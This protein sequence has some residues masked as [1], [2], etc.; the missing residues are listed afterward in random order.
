M[1]DLSKQEKK[2]VRELIE[3]G[4]IRDY[5]DGI[6]SAKDVCDSYIEGKSD[7]KEYYHKLFSVLHSKDKIIAKRYDGITGSHYIMRLG[8][9]FS[10]GVLTQ[11][12][13]Q[14]VDE[15]LKKKLSPYM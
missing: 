9:L 5:I 13:L 10:D 7:P 15:N 12:D 6:K 11:A 4:L 3:R 8:I 14:D 1:A 2:K